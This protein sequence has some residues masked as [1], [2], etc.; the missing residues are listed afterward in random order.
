M[1]DSMGK[2]TPKQNQNARL[3]IP[4]PRKPNNIKY[5]LETVRRLS[6]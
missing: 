4:S 5:K 2:A 6:F 1:E 3:K